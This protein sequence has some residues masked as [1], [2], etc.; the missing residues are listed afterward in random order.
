MCAPGIRTVSFLELSSL[1]N[2]IFSSLSLAIQVVSVVGFGLAVS[3]LGIDHRLYNWISL[4]VSGLGLPSSICY[5]LS[6]A[7]SDLGLP[8]K[9]WSF[10][11]VA[12]FFEDF[13]QSSFSLDFPAVSDLGFALSSL[14]SWI[15]LQSILLDFTTISVHGFC[16]GLCP[17][18]IFPVCP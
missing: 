10:I 2:L 5:W 13:P 17:G 4:A 14:C 3:F 12:V 15:S 11:S 9:V 8:I 18:Y 7:V 6:S 16:S 1:H